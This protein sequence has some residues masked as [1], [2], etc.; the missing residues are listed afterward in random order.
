MQETLDGGTMGRSFASDVEGTGIWWLH[1]MGLLF[2]TLVVVR[3][4]KR[5]L[6]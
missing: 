1:V 5:L 6:V 3:V 4:T 2:A